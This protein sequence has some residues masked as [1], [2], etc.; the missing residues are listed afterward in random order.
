MPK[1]K[2]VG[3]VP[4]VMKKQ[5]ANKVANLLFEKRPKN[6]DIGQDTKP[7]KGPHLLCQ[8]T[9]LY[10]AVATQLLMLATN[11]GQR[12]VRGCWPMLRRKL[13]A[14]KMFPLRDRWSFEQ[15]SVLS[16]PWWRTRRLSWWLITRYLR[17]QSNSG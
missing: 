14:K 6:T 4:A 11:T 13:L 7:K 3:S 9:L 15:G 5:E 8:T 12:R 10:P 2:K 16:L 1:G 17:R